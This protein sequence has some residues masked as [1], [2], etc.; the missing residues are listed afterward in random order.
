VGES[1]PYLSSA[2]VVLDS[3]RR[4]ANV[5]T[6]RIIYNQAYLDHGFGADVGDA[7]AGQLWAT[8]LTPD[9][10]PTARQHGT[11]DVA[12][13]LPKVE[14]GKP[15]AGTDR[16][17]GFVQPDL[18][19][20]GLSMLT[21]AVGDVAGMETRTFDPKE[22][23]KGAF[24]KLFGLVDLW[25]IIDTVTDL[26]NIPNLVSEAVEVV[27]QLVDDIQAMVDV[28]QEV[29]ATAEAEAANAADVLLAAIDGLFTTVG[30]LLDP[31]NPAP[32]S[33]RI[34]DLSDAF[35]AIAVQLES[36]VVLSHPQVPPVVRG[37]LQALAASIR[38]AVAGADLVGE[39]TRLLETFEPGTLQFRFKY[40]FTPKLFTRWPASGITLISLPERGFRLAVEGR[41]TGNGDVSAK[42]M[43]EIRD[44][45]LHLFGKE[46]EPGA[47]PLVRIPFENISFI[48]GS[49]GKPEVDV[50]LGEITF[51]GILSFVEVL[52]DLIPL[53]GFSDPP[54]L[55]V[56]PSGLKAGFTLPIPSVSVGV[57]NLSNIS[58]GADVQVPFLGEAISFGFDFCTRERPFNLSVMCIGGG[59]WFGIRL[60]PK[61]LT[62]LELGLEAGVMLAVDFGV[63]SGSISAT[64]G[65]YMRLES[66]KG[67]LTG[68]FRL[69][70]EVDV[71]G[72]ISA[73]I[74]L[75]L[76]L[77][78]HFDSG[79]MIGTARITI[80][81]SVLCFSASVSIECTRQF[82]GSKG[83][84]SLAQQLLEPDGTSPAWDEYWGAFA[85]EGA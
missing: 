83:D 44:F 45:T 33:D 64:L 25:D 82:A 21:G 32:V 36:P 53:D 37:K 61:G 11:L 85:L 65:I 42:A 16:A 17:G 20:R 35:E 71:L 48:A 77:E 6:V 1:T 75:Y 81:V 56:D 41:V 80:E 46:G 15:S 23:F 59:G 19:I 76:S 43:A 78:Y 67:S 31:G 39:L 70:G 52:K 60:N 30:D 9:V 84:P 58:L 38:A 68:Y 22:F 72:L 69:R 5:D 2:D 40:E 24:P 50:N 49:D 13:P 27:T 4:L 74:E 73:S 79:K 62:V 47:A 51:C 34:Q 18:P 57:F 54:F 63:A 66:D 28:L 8:V 14:F 55:E 12:R 3:A 10:T 7:N 29:A 26:A